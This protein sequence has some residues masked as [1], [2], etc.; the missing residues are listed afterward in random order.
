[1]EDKENPAGS[2]KQL[3]SQEEATEDELP[4][5]S[6]QEQEQQQGTETPSE[7]LIMNTQILKL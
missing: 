4:L 6:N 5:H 1:M 7:I 3:T 2:Y